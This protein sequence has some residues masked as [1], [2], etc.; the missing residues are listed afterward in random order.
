MTNMPTSKRPKKRKLSVSL[1]PIHIEMLN[2]LLD[3]GIGDNYSTAF[4]YL[5]QEKYWQKHEG[6]EKLLEKVQ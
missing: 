4:G 3:E 5:I 2:D 6:V 1:S